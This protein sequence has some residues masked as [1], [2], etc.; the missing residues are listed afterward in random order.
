MVYLWEFVSNNMGP[1]SL[2]LVAGDCRDGQLARICLCS[3]FS[4]INRASYIFGYN[5]VGCYKPKTARAMVTF[6]KKNFRQPMALPREGNT[7][8]T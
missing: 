1:S 8:I 2:Q 3:W 7:D 4:F 5:S 6:Q